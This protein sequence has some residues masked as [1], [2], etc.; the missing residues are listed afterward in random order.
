MMCSAIV[1]NPDAGG[2][3]QKLSAKNLGTFALFSSNLR[4]RLDSDSVLYFIK[5]LNCG[6]IETDK[7]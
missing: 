3:V 1:S 6:M 7:S 5:Q 2:I 4:S